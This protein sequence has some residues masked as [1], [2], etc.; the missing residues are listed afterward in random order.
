[1][2]LVVLLLL[3][4]PLLSL[5]LC[6]FGVVAHAQTQAIADGRITVNG[7]KADPEHKLS[8]ADDVR[9]LIHRHEPPVDGTPISIVAETDSYV[10]GS[11][12]GG[13]PPC[14]RLT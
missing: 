11:G 1:M 5:A 9:H 8:L 7:A 14:R 12:S 2:L 13:T 6:V 3:L 10:S 4:P